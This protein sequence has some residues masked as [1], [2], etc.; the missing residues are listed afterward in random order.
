M[1]KNT[2]VFFYYLMMHIF[3]H[4]ANIIGHGF[5]LYELFGSFGKFITVSVLGLLS[6]HLGK[7][8]HEGNNDCNPMVVKPGFYEEVIKYVFYSF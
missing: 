4:K 3:I 5:V 7:L 2:T 1:E 6:L 8:Q